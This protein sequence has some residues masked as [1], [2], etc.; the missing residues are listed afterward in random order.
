MPCLDMEQLYVSSSVKETRVC[1]SF[2]IIS[3]QQK[4]IVREKE[5][6]NGSVCVCFE[7][8]VVSKNENR[9]RERAATPFQQLALQHKNIISYLKLRIA[10]FC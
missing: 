7:Q 9:A 2:N 4:I 6:E 8:N 3:H 1:L 10:L 5:R